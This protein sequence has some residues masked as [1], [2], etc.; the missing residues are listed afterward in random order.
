MTKRNCACILSK[1]DAFAF[2]KRKTYWRKPEQGNNWDQYGDSS[3]AASASVSAKEGG[4]GV[5]NKSEKFQEWGPQSPES[6]SSKHV[7]SCQPYSTRSSNRRSNSWADW[8]REVSG[9]V[10]SGSAFLFFS[11]LPP[12]SSPFLLLGPARVFVPSFFALA[13]QDH[14]ARRRQVRLASCHVSLLFFCFLS[15]RAG[16]PL[17]CPSLSLFS[18][19]LSLSLLHAFVRLPSAPS[20]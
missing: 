3:S 15:A 18:F 2:T 13:L 5:S 16:S 10:V 14:F 6:V 9:A 17:P 7:Q 1:K 8:A 4:R 19:C 11:P 20:S 12:S